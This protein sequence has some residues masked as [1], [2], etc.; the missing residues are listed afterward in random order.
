[1]RVHTNG[2]ELEVESTGDGEPLILIMGLGAQLIHWPDGLVSGFE[3]RGFRVIRFDNRD[4]GLS[5]KFDHIKLQPIQSMMYRAWLGLPIEPAYTLSD[6]AR[7]VVGL[8]DELAIERAHIVGASMGGMIAQLLAIEHPDRVRSLTSIM[9]TP[10][11][12]RFATVSPSAYRALLG[13]APRTRE[14][15]IER[16]FSFIDACGSRTWPLDRARLRDVAGRAYDRCYCPRGFV[17]QLSAVLASKSRVSE[18]RRL[19]VPSLVIHGSVDGLV[20]LRAGQATADAIPGARLRVIR[21]MG[22]DLPAGTWPL[23]ADAIRS[24]AESATPPA[25]AGAPSVLRAS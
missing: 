3:T 5:T 20:P 1:M 18:L 13:P 24:L 9:S 10:G 12:R 7:D 6:M 4:V 16:A 17:R 15:A 14:Q 22:H 11:G 8:L 25:R 2:I 19:A 21:G 23:I